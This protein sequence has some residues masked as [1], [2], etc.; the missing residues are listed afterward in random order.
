MLLT[1]SR[2]NTKISFVGSIGH[3]T[4]F[5]FYATKT[6]TTGEGGMITTDN[7]DW[8]KRMR[9]LRL[10]GVNRDAWERENDENFWEYDI[11][12]PGYKYNTTDINSAMGIEQLKKARQVK[13]SP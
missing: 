7:P 1:R 12:E 5:S 13:R 3:A 2:Q 6:I 8:A 10:H 11:N 4:C 9:T